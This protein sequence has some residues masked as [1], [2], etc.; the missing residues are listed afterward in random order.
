MVMAGRK[1]SCS[2]IFHSE[3]GSMLP[4][5]LAMLLGFRCF[6]LLARPLIR[7]IINPVTIVLCLSGCAT[8]SSKT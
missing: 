1:E 3:L 4:R 5:L 7:V 2:N 8:P 6:G